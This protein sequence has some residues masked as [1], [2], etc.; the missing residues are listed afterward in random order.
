MSVF[1]A[2]WVSPVASSNIHD[3]AAKNLKLGSSLHSVKLRGVCFWCSLSTLLSLPLG[4]PTISASEASTVEGIPSDNPCLG[5]HVFQVFCLY[6]RGKNLGLS[7]SPVRQGRHRLFLWVSPQEGIVC[8]FFF[9]GGYCLLLKPVS[10]SDLEGT[11]SGAPLKYLR[12]P[13]WKVL[14]NVVEVLLLPQNSTLESGI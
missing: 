13:P 11:A 6:G 7:C 5:P 8:F 14:T 12:H 4:T 10:A 2:R 9:G 1:S 3:N